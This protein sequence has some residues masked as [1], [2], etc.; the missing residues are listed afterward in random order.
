MTERC[1]DAS[2]VLKLV[3]KGEPH[4]ATA[5]RLLRDAIAND[6]LLIA[7]PFFESE[8]DSDVRKRVFEGTMTIA[9]AKRAYAWSYR[10]GNQNKV[11]AVLEIPPVD[12]PE[13]A[14]KAA[15]A[16]KARSN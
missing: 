15:L 11:V 7:P 5:R 9:E 1:V 16:S 3:F 10:D 12:S 8:V 6:D 13:S 4:R 2:V 14:V